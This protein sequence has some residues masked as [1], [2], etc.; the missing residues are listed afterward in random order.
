[1]GPSFEYSTLGFSTL[2]FKYFSADLNSDT[3]IVGVNIPLS[4]IPNLNPT[5]EDY[6]FQYAI[7]P[8]LIYLDNTEWT[9][10]EPNSSSVDE[11]GR[12]LQCIFDEP[13]GINNDNRYDIVFRVQPID[14]FS[15]Y[16]KYAAYD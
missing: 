16:W 15:N 14:L 4:A 1:M 8:N 13:A 3:G 11:V 12:V 7:R 5:A 2:T 6:R 9:T 10:I